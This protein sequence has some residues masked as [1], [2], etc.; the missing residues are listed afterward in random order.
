M[1]NKSSERITNL[2]KDAKDSVKNYANSKIN[3][4]GESLI[5][6]A[7]R[8]ATKEQK[9]SAEEIAQWRANMSKILESGVSRDIKEKIEIKEETEST[10]NIKK[11]RK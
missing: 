5:S 2:F 9:N 7:N 3:A 10:S 6:Y 1:T 4:L 8:D 11:L